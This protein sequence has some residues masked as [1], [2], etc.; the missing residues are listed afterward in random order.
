MPASGKTGISDRPNL[1]IKISESSGDPVSKEG[2]RNTIPI[3]MS[4]PI[5]EI[6]DLP[7]NTDEG[8]AKTLGKSKE[9]DATNTKGSISL[10]RRKA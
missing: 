5:L 1:P 4:T 9:P 2:S 3:E 6:T 8:T 7:R 10:I